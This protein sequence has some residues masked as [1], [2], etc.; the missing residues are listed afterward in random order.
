MVGYSVLTYECVNANIQ[1]RDGEV[2]ARE[3]IS[4]ED[5]RRFYNVKDAEI[6][7]GPEQGGVPVCQ[8]FV[9]LT[10]LSTKLEV[11]AD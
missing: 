7:K 1:S 2:G 11:E 4:D 8:M 6:V 3:Y 9:C 5:Y 10:A